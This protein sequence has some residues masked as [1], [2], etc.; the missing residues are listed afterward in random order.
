MED[1]QEITT[2]QE[3]SIDEILDDMACPSDT[4][5]PPIEPGTEN[6]EVAA[7]Y[8]Q[9]RELYGIVPKFIQVLA[10]SPGAAR[11][12]LVFDRDVKV[13]TLRAEEKER[14]R[15]QV[16]CI[17]K[18]SLENACHNCAHHNVALARQLGF[19]DEQLSSISSNSWHEN[20]EFSDKEK[21][22]LD[23]ANA[24]TD[25][26]ARIKDDTFRKMTE[27]FSNSEIVELTYTTAL[28]NCTNRLAEAL[29]I[30]AEPANKGIHWDKK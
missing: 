21:V 20:V 18:P 8:D 9:C 27:Y 29:H 22:V 28:W 25:M 14:S 2:S 17:L 16:L 15:L 6:A 23:W 7:L 3:K 1:V 11:S 24:T 5:I 30:T 12:F 13:A 26:S 19:S 4:R 10:H